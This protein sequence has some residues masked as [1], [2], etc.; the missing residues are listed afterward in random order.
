MPVFSNR[1]TS[2]K[3][4]T[5]QLSPNRRSLTISALAN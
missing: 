3:E 4:M 1:T 2:K 5:V